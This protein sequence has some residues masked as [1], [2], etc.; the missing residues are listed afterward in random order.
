MAGN[1]AP[2]SPGGPIDQS[3]FRFGGVGS[4]ASPTQT[5][6]GPA[7]QGWTAS[8]DADRERIGGS[9]DWGKTTAQ[10]TGKEPVRTFYGPMQPGQADGSG[11]IPPGATPSY[12]PA[13]GQVEW[14]TTP[15]V[16][17]SQSRPSSAP[18]SSSSG[19]GGGGA[20]SFPPPS[21]SGGLGGFGGGGE[22]SGGGSGGG[23]AAAASAPMM[24]LQA[25]GGEGGGAQQDPAAPTYM[26]ALQGLRQGLGIRTNAPPSNNFTQRI[27]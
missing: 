13:S 25:A 8:T 23:Y 21:S 18:P 14:M 20:S 15:S 11:G 12:N 27:Y 3:T 6:G 16:G 7:A 19:G 24:G 2:R 4:P 10:L 1:F 26:S 5:G 17:G 22:V 9:A